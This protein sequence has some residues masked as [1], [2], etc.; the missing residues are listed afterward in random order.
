MN[1]CSAYVPQ[2]GLDEEEKKRFLEVLN[3]V[4]KGVPSS[5][6]IF[7]GG[8]F[9]RHIGSLPMGYDDVHGGFVFRDKNVEGAAL[10]DFTRAFGLVVVNSSFP[11]KDEYLGLE[12]KGREKRLFKLAKAKERKG[13]DLDQVK[14][15]KGENGRVLVEDAFIKKRWQSY[16]HKLLNDE[17]DRGVVLGKLEHT[18]E[19]H[20][21]VYYRH[22]KVKEVS[23]AIR[24]M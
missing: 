14:C 11:K 15:I 16:F 10:L 1:I 21:F 4:V 3:E 6:I 8:D 22:F 5:E 23:E 12:E 13:L 18:E 19:C 24:K 2:G 20:D 17:R 7:I 9:N